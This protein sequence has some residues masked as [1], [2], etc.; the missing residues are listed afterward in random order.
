MKSSASDNVPF[1]PKSNRSFGSRGLYTALSSA[2][3]V[4]LIPQIS[5]S[6]YQSL[7]LRASHEASSMSTIPTL[8]RP[9]SAASRWK[10]VRYVA[11]LPER[12][13]Q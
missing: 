7:L 9:T 10:P 1:T 4:P 13:S 11:V 2:M 6:R 3:S 5:M 8:P 12:P